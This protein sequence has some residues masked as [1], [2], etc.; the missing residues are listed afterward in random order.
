MKRSCL[1][2]KYLNT[3]SDLDREAHN[4][5]RNYVDRFLRKE[6]KQFH[7]NLNTNVLT[8]NRTFWKTVKPFLAD[9]S[10]KTSRKTLTVEERVISQN[11]LISKTFHEYFTSIRIKNM[12]K[13]NRKPNM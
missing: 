2:N 7:S 8:E 4:K 5:Q 10:D 11:H 13:R 1:R 12:P 3:R 9:K 6:K